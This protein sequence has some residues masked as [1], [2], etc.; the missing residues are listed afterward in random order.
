MT[1][2]TL[3]RAKKLRDGLLSTAK[4]IRLR[5]DGDAQLNEHDAKTCEDAA[6]MLQTLGTEVDRLRQ[7]VG[8]FFEGRLDRATLKN[9]VRTWNL[10]P[11]NPRYVTAKD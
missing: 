4:E 8:C 7:G 5:R 9:M 10:P 3:A 11:T 1:D 2:E 6:A